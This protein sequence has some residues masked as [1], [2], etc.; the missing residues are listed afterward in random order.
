MARSILAGCASVPPACSPMLIAL[1]SCTRRRGAAT[2]RAAAGAAVPPLPPPR[3]RRPPMRSR[4]GVAGRAAARHAR[5]PPLTAGP[6]AAPPSGSA[7]PT[8]SA[9]SD[10]SGL[11]RPEDWRA[12]AP[13]PR[14][15]RSADALAFFATHFETGQVGDGA[16]FATGYYEPEIAGSRDAGAGLSRC[17]SMPSPPDL[18]DDQSRDRRRAAAA[19]STRAAH[20]VLYHERAAIEDGALAGRGLEIGWAAD[21]VDLFFLQIQGSG[22]LR[23][24]DGGGDADRLCRPERPRICRDR[25]A[26]ARAR[27]A[28]RRRS[29]MQKIIDWLRAH[30]EEGR[31]MM[32]ENRATSS[33]AS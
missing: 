8:S 31:A 15:G 23:L 16:A 6:R 18:L 3:R 10:A 22:R 26:A 4:P 11:T 27:P 12:P 25:P 24:P 21:P 33:S 17:R 7:A 1:A 14:P 13:P 19:G 9:A 32:R 29:R 2:G 5:R 30:P 20:Y 28:R